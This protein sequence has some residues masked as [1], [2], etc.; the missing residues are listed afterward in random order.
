MRFKKSITVNEIKNEY[1]PE[2]YISFNLPKKKLDLSTF[3]MYFTANCA[4]AA[5]TIGFNTVGV[6]DFDATLVDTAIS[7]AT[8]ATIEIPGHGF[9]NS[10]QDVIYRVGA[11]NTKIT[12][13]TNGKRYRIMRVDGN[14]IRISE[15]DNSTSATN[16]RIQLTAAGTGLQSFE[17]VNRTYKT[18]GRFLPNPHSVVEELV[19]KVNNEVKQHIK[20]Y[21]TI[22]SILN[23]IKREYD[24][25]DSTS[26]DTVQQLYLNDKFVANKSK[27][28]A[29][30][31]VNNTDFPVYNDAN[32]QSYY[33]NRFLGFLGEGSRYFDATDKDIQITIKLANPAIQYKGVDGNSVLSVVQVSGGIEMQNPPYYVL[34]NVWCT[35]DVLDEMPQISEYVYKDYIFHEG[36]YL[37]SNKK[38]LTRVSVDKP[39]EWLL[40][41]FKHPNYKSDQELQLMH[42]HADT[43]KFG[44][45]L[46]DD[47]AITDINTQTPNTLAYSYEISKLQKDPYI[48]NNSIYFSH[49]GDGISYCK[50]RW[51][52]YELTPQMDLIT[53]Y[54]ETKKC[55]DSDFKRVTSIF[56]FESD[57]FVNAVRVDDTSNQYKTI[58]W[59]VEVDTFKTNKK[60]GFPML[61]V[62]TTN[63]I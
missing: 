57:F 40:G 59:E 42:C 23:G 30:V 51:N 61:F 14:R 27:I 8:A 49:Q 47:L 55:F 20:H 3:T 1:Q 24:E 50:Y 18:V 62:C 9:T 13:L 48:L 7:G 44:K 25:V 28:Q 4:N 33:I 41:T 35:V 58:E 53:C 21:N 17:L 39:V 37:E 52:N 12:P 54:N 43:A 63:K 46:K 15:V 11:G 5:H 45:L 32:T 56:N 60:G 38:F 6:L 34:K 26:N 10:S 16:T 31:R 36:H 19:I 2:T 29:I 22:H